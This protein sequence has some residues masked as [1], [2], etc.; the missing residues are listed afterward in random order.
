MR[1]DTPADHL[2]LRPSITYSLAHNYKKIQR[3][4]FGI[5]PVIEDQITKPSA[6]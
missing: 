6:A 4:L 3:P 2:A 5:M 1:Q